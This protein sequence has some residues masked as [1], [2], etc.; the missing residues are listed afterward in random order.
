[1]LLNSIAEWL[2]L[3]KSRTAALLE[4]ARVD[5]SRR[6]EQLTLEELARIADVFYDE[7]LSL[8]KYGVSTE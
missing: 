4:A 5:G 3:G 8:S 6:A 1:M 2:R 7:G